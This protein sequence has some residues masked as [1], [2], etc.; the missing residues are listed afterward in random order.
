[1]EPLNIALLGCGTVGGGTAQILTE[2]KPVLTERAA[3]EINLKKIVEIQPEEAVK[4]FDLPMELFCGNGKS[5]TKEESNQFIDEILQDPEINMVIET[6]GGSNDWI[7]NLAIKT[8]KAKKH[9]IT[10]NKA[11]LAERGNNIFKHAVENKVVVGFEAAVCGAIPIIK[12]IN[13]SFS[14]DEVISL[15]GIMNGTSNYIL[16][17]MQN[18]G[19]DF[20]TVLKMAQDNGYAEADPTLDINGG[21]AGHKIC[22]LMKLAFGVDISMNQLSVQGIENITQEEIDFAKEIDSKIKLICY[23]KKENNKIYTTVQPMMVKNNNMLAEINGATNAVRVE[24][25]YSGMQVLIGSGAGSTETASSIVADII[26][27][28]R[29]AEQIP[30]K[31]IKT[32]LQ[33]IDPDKFTFSYLIIFDTEDIPGITGMVTTCIGNQNI[34]ID[35]VS[36]NR[37]NIDKAVFSIATMPC[38]KEQISMAI[39]QIKKQKPDILLR[40][41]RIIPILY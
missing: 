32:N 6:I 33:P 17:K 41:P 11:L 29:Y 15:S 8:L 13:E 40:E 3:R 30:K 22:I 18:E 39:Q 26:Y 20:E 38:S 31:F 23:A 36:H 21:D 2:M 16:S 19:L 4:R 12:T 37:H 1:M 7:E 14:G 9:L 27:I 10:A 25:K 28:A 5:L 35:T 24:N 34:N